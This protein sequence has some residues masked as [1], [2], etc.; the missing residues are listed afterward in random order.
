MR[1]LIRLGEQGPEISL[2]QLSSGLALN[3][4]T[5]HRLLAAMQKFHLIER[6]PLNEKYRLGIKFH[7]LGSGALHARSLQF[8]ARPFLLELARRSNESVSLRLRRSRRRRYHLSRPRR[9][10]HF[11]H[12][13]PHTHRRT[14]SRALHR[15]SQS[16]PRVAP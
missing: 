15:A 6:N 16:Y 14:L 11:H 12:H 3:K 5:V 1:I 13:C 8:E 10:P 2:A 9:F 7:E 4:S